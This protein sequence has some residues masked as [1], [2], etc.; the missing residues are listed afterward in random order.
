MLEFPRAE[1]RSC[2]TSISYFALSCPNCHA[3]N[4]PNPVAT[5]TA[6]LVV[7]A[8][9]AAIGVG[10]AIFRYKQ[11]AQTASGAADAGS[12]PS[13]DSTAD[14]GW[15]MEAMAKCE[16]GAK[17]KMDTLQF[18]IVPVTQTGLSLP[19]WSPSTIGDVGSSAKLLSATDALFGLRNRVLV[20]Y[21]K[22]LTFLISDPKTKTM[23]KWQ[24]AVGVVEL[25]TRDFG[26]GDLRLGFEMPDVADDIEWG[27]TVGIS[28][29]TCYWINVL[30]LASRRNT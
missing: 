11:S 17:Q 4:Q 24:P 5:I 7:I 10:A 14:Y 25:D 15:I 23:Y 9:G 19:G 22:P 3:L 18:L 21:N 13:A 29:G 6:L 2:G 16:A 27:P 8:M 1:C 28:K 26:F 30:V 12:K 20:P